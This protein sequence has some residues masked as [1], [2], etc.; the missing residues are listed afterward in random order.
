MSTRIEGPAGPTQAGPNEFGESVN[1]VNVN[2]SFFHRSTVRLGLI[3][4]LLLSCVP[5]WAE[6]EAGSAEKQ[7]PKF[8]GP[9]AVETIMEEDAEEERPIFETGFLD[10]YHEWKKRYAERTG[11]NYGV[12]YS[13]VFLRASES[14]NKDGASGGMIRFYGSL[15]AVGRGSANTGAFVWKVEHRHRYGSLPPSGFEFNLG[16]VGIIEPPFSNEGTRVTNLYWRQRMNEGR[17]VWVAGFLDATDY[18]DVYALASPWT[19]FTN[20]AFSTGTT[21][22]SLP[23]DALLGFAVA[24]MVTNRMYIIGGLGDTNSDPTDPFEGFNTFFDDHEYF[25]HVEVGWTTS[26][27][28]IYLDNMHFTI[29][30]A[31]ERNVALVPDDWGI[32]FSFSHFVNDR[33]MPFVRAGWADE[34]VALMKKSVSAGIGFQPPWERDLIGVAL[35]WGDPADNFGPGLDDQYTLEAFYRL[36]LSDELAITPTVQL[37]RDPALNPNEDTIWLFGLRARIAL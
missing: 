27:D 8:G 18:V 34:G 15:D 22:I 19:G 21:T 6:S 16:S 4:A 31:D 37:L 26:Q 25:K 17:F 1:M 10:P 5:G 24:G 32:N 28:R 36:Q 14:P 23:N 9:D 13:S 7:P 2:R 33:W 11:V 20:F 12:D 30:H 29:W 3:A 35:N